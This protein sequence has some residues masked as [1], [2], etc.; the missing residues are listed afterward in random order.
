MSPLHH[1]AVVI[2]GATGMLGAATAAELARRG[3]D[4]VLVARDRTRGTALLERL[5]GTRGTHRLVLGDL[6]EPG[7]VRA[8]AAEISATYPRVGA[9]VHAAATLTPQRRTNSAGHEVMFATNVLARFL[10]TNDLAGPLAA[11]SARVVFATGATPDALDFDDLMATGSWNAFR[12]FRATNA[13]SHQ[14]ALELARRGESAG[15]AGNAFHPGVLQSDLMGQMPAPVRVLTAPF[16][17]SADKA[18]AALA[19]LVDG[20]APA[21]A[22]YKRTK[23][24][25]PPKASRDA[26]S[27]RRLWSTAA[28]LL[29]ID[30]ADTIGGAD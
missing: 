14:L 5:G 15:I 24:A 21:G 22:Y 27:Q 20:G 28:T 3:T 17:R 29:G 25:S 6:S 26:G 18:A 30:V 11:G 10:L 12:Q 9:L 2:T 7:S 8:A 23:R 1:E 13:A 19:D 4:T 16:G